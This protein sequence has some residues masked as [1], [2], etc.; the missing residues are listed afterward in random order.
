MDQFTLDQFPLDQLLDQFSNG[1]VLLDEYSPNQRIYCHP[2]NYFI[3]ARQK[4]HVEQIIMRLFILNKINIFG[5]VA[6]MGQGG[7]PPNKVFARLVG[8]GWYIES[9]QNK[10]FSNKNT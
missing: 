1:R 2:C 8:L 5:V 7:R 6:S 3:N 4:S 10:K 9:F